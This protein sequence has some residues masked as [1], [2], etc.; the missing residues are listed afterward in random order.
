MKLET[1]AEYSI[2]ANK[3]QKLLETLKQHGCRIVPKEQKQDWLNKDSKYNEVK[4]CEIQLNGTCIAEIT[5]Y[6][7]EKNLFVPSGKWI[8]LIYNGSESDLENICKQDIS[9]QEN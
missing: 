7:I 2:K 4:D 6:R 5:P 1:P 8:L 9:K 3:Y